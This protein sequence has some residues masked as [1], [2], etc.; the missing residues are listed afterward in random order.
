MIQIQI[1][2]KREILNKFRLMVTGDGSG[3]TARSAFN[4]IKHRI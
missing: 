2:A 4:L 3:V 1:S